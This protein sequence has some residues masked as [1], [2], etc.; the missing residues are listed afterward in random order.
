MYKGEEKG[1]GGKETLTTVDGTIGSTG[2]V[3]TGCVTSVVAT[4]SA[5]RGFGE[6]GRA[7]V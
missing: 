6:I 3:L 5:A 7:H 1:S 4:P 2:A